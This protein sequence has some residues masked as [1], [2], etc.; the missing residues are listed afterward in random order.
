MG[1]E[2]NPSG[3]Q[4]RCAQV[5]GNGL[6]DPALAVALAAVRDRKL[7]ASSW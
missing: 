3:L 2:V 5:R 7:S 1:V 6:V 4:I